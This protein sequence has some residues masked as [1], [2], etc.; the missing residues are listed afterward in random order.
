MVILMCYNGKF[1]VFIWFYQESY[2]GNTPHV[3]P[4]Q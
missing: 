2:D 3:Q 4:R 1:F